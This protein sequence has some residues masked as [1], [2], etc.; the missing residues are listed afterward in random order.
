MVFADEPTGSL[1][2]ATGRVILDM[3]R[4]AA[5]GG[6][7][8]VLVTHDLNLASLADR[9]IVLSDGLVRDELVDPTP[10]RVLQSFSRFV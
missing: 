8:V 4:E 2:T 9:V 3:L 7:T 1:D 10:E 6:S 5:D